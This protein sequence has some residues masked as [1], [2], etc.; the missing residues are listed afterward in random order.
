[1]GKLIGYFSHRLG[2][3]PEACRAAMQSL[4]ESDLEVIKANKNRDL[5]KEPGNG[6]DVYF[7]GTISENESAAKSL[8][9]RLGFREVG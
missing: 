5:I 6:R 1:V 2:Y 4:V 3:T 7:G 9:G 8:T